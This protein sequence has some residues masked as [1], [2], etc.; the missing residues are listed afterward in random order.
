MSITEKSFREKKLVCSVNKT[1]IFKE[2][3]KDLAEPSTLDTP[4]IA[5]GL[6]MILQ[7][8]FFNSDPQIEWWFSFS[9][10][11]VSCF[12]FGYDGLLN[13]CQ[14]VAPEFP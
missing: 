5:K 7:C 2:K 12:N 1:T 11:V 9:I 10:R 6:T 14:S 3:E 8:C 13:K 4:G